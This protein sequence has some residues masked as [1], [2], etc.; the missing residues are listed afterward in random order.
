MN[1]GDDDDDDDDDTIA[2]VVFVRDSATGVPGT[3][4]W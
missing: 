2:V 3:G 1:K 4:T